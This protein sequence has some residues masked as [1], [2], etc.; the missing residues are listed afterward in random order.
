[1]I[2]LDEE[3]GFRSKTTKRPF[4]AYLFT[5]FSCSSKHNPPSDIIYLRHCFLLAFRVTILDCQMGRPRSV[6]SV[7]S[8]RNRPESASFQSAPPSFVFARSAYQNIASRKLLLPSLERNTMHALCSR[9][10]DMAEWQERRMSEQ[11]SEIGCLKFTGY[12]CKAARW[13]CKWICHEWA[14]IGK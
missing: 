9:N 4:V 8:R 13:I 3:D 5:S 6:F 14:E 7:L 2:V 12:Q 11:L 10:S 1:M